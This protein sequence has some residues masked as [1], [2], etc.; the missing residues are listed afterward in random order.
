M[1]LDDLKRD[2]WEIIDN[3]SEIDVILARGSQRIVVDPDGEIIITYS[4]V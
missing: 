1:T 2:G 3:F 4:M